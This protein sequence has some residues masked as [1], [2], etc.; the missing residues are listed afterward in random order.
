MLMPCAGRLIW[1]PGS[2]IEC[3]RENKTTPAEADVVGD[4]WKSENRYT[5]IVASLCCSRGDDDDGAGRSW[6]SRV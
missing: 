6:D 4:H 3:L 2:G 1:R 5:I